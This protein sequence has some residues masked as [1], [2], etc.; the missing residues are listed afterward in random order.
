MPPSNSVASAY[1]PRWTL[2]ELSSISTLGP[3][4]HPD[5]RGFFVQGA[6]GRAGE[7]LGLAAVALGTMGGAGEGVG[8]GPAMERLGLL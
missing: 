3:A 5:R 4:C 6:S 2:A 7:G 1:K 8:R